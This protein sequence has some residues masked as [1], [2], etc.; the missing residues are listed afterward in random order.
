M[1]NKFRGVITKTFKT[2]DL[3]DEDENLIEEGEEV[4][5]RFVMDFNALCMIEEVIGEE[6]AKTF[7]ARATVGD[8]SS[9]EL[10][11][12]YYASMLRYQPDATLEYAGE[13]MSYL[14]QA[15]VEIM[16]IAMPKAEPAKAG[17][18]KKRAKNPVK[19]VVTRV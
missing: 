9:T 4:T 8:I 19:K 7:S 18:G 11:A 16:T 5:V 2:D 17:A 1:S 3:F 10:R 12:V 15:W 13:V 14:P 6:R